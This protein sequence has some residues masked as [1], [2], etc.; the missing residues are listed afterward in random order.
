MIDLSFGSLIAYAMFLI[1]GVFIGLGLAG[2]SKVA[3]AAYDEIRER[4]ERA[5]NQLREWRA[6]VKAKTPK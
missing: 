1:A 3:Q 2:R 5:E 6:E 4:A